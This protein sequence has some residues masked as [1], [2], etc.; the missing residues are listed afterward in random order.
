MADEVDEPEGALP[1][2]AEQVHLP[3]P[4]YLP[5]LMAM[6]ITFMVVGV[7]VTKYLL[8]LGAILFVVV[9]VKWVRSTR[10]EMSELPLE[11]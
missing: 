6:G 4:S 1:P 9:L 10:E 5:P 3:D 7:V 2:P 8:V 11:H